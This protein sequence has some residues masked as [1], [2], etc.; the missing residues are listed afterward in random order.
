MAAVQSKK[1]H[2]PQ[3]HPYDD[4]NTC[5]SGGKRV[6]LQCGKDRRS[7]RRPPTPTPLDIFTTRWEPDGDCWRW[8][9]ALQN[10][11]YGQYGKPAVLAHRW[12]YELHVGPIP[13]DLVVDHLCRNRWCVNPE[14]LEVVTLAENIIRGESLPAKNKRKTHCP[15]GHPYDD[16]NTHLT[17]QGWRICR[18]CNRGRR[19][20]PGG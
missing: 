20:S 11:G 17:S 1:T 18:A 6:C 15:K 10:A 5:H 8:T 2:C 12:S 16:E 4:R 13:T 19:R 7:A 9:G 14:H 3:G